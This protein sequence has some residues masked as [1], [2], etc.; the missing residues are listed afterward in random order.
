MVP[1]SGPSQPQFVATGPQQRVVGLK[2]YGD[3]GVLAAQEDAAPLAAHG[4]TEC[5]LSDVPTQTAPR[6]GLDSG[7]LHSCGGEGNLET[8]EIKT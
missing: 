1:Q 2:Y 5:S 6:G 8:P 4:V 7:G 3:T